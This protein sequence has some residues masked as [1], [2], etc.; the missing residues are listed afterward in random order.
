MIL[1]A[2]LGNLRLD[3]VFVFAGGLQATPLAIGTGVEIDIAMIDF[4]LVGRRRLTNRTAVLAMR[5]PTTI[6][7]LGG[8]LAIGL[9]PIRFTAPF[10]LVFEFSD[11]RIALGQRLLQILHPHLQRFQLLL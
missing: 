7:L 9:R 4:R 10:Q 8:G 5:S 2:R 3:V 11:P 6:G 1:D